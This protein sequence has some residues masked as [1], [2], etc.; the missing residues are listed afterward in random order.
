MGA[1]MTDPEVRVAAEFMAAHAIL[2]LGL[3]VV[4][5]LAALAAVIGAVQLLRRHRDTVRAGFVAALQFA[6]RLGVVEHALARSRPFVPS[7]YL[8]LHLALGLALTAAATVFLIVVEDVVSGGEMVAFDLAFAHALAAAATPAW[9]Q[10]FATVS[11]LGEKEAIA[12]ATL[13]VAA[14][15]AFTHSPLVAAGWI[16]AQAGGGVLNLALKAT[17]E[18]TR[19]PFAD[20][21]LAASSWSFPSGHAMGTFILFGLGCYV[22]LRDM[23]SWT[24]AAVAVTLSLAWCIVMAFSRLYLGVHFASDVAAGVIAGAA[25]VAVCASAFEVVRRRHGRQHPR[26][27]YG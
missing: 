5:A 1:A 10:V 13:V 25:W 19:P 16:G 7:A 8:A 17:F 26:A 6:R 18:R 3:A 4:M 2:L 21:E 22:L 14:R 27:H 20:P 24:L 12:V 23:R 11:W 15:L 9:Q